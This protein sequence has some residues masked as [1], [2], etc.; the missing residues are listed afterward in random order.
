[1][2]KGQLAIQCREYPQTLTDITKGRRNMNAALSLKLEKALG[3]E[4]GYFMTL[5]IL[6]D[7]R[8]GHFLL[9]WSFGR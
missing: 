4:E 8:H 6:H 2:K 9:C 3:L 1:M 7:H 5:Q